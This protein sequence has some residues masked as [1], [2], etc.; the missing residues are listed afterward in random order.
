MPSLLSGSTLRRG[1]SNTFID[2]KGAQPQFP[3]NADTST[4]YTIVTNALFVTTVTSSLGNIEFYKGKMYSNIANQNIQLI[5]TGTSTVIVLGGTA[6]TSTNTGALLVQGGIGI[7]NGLWTGEDIHVNGLTIGQGFK[8]VNNIVIQGA[9]NTLSN[10]IKDGEHSIAIGYDALLG[11]SKSL[12]TI[13]IGRYALSSGTNIAN[14]IAIGDRA[15]ALV[16]TTQT[17]FIS[18]V[19]NISSANPLIVTANNHGLSSGTNIIFNGIVGT[20]ELNYWTNDLTSYY[21]KRL[22]SSTFSLY[23][24]VNLTISV[25][26]TLLTPYVS[27]GIIERPYFLDDNIALGVDAGASLIDGKQNFFLGKSIASNFSTGS[28]NLFIGH[29]V[30]NNMI[31]GNAN[32]AI[33]GDNLIDGVDNQIN[34]G[35]V[36]YYD[37]GGNLQLNANTY[38]GLG[39]ESTS[40]TNGGLVVFGG[41]GISDNLYVGTTATILGNA[42]IGNQLEVTNT[43]TF[44]KDVI[45][46]RD[47]I[48]D[49]LGRVVLSP[50]GNN[51]EIQPSAG[52][53]L[54][55]SVS[56][57]STMDGVKIGTV[58]TPD[59]ANFSDVNIT[60]LW[61]T[62]TIT[63][64]IFTSTNIGGGFKGSLP[65]QSSTGTTAFIP[66]GNIGQV[67][68][69]G[70][71]N[72]ATWSDPANLQSSTASNADNIFIHDVTSNVNPVT[73]DTVFHIA[74]T[75][76]T[77]A[78]SQISGSDNFSYD[79]RENRLT[80]PNLTVTNTLTVIKSVFSQDGGVNENNLLYTPRVTISTSTPTTPRVGDFWI[81]PNFGVELQYID[82][83]GTRFWIQFT[84]I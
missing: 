4:G 25:N 48:A 52:G 31:R 13:A 39:G 83:G 23:Q 73:Q 65:I 71:N 2:L 22:T 6:N 38:L 10:D 63:G 76:A 75:T 54:T 36:F 56:G 21:V 45:V 30:A 15:L 42:F 84:G 69:V 18:T 78:F 68:I 17:E 61:V 81:N 29:D 43:G 41:V 12:K 9:V 33:G 27:G 77:N 34:I 19:S 67:L 5:G 11:I 60:S 57:N 7:Q 28:Y 3:P 53:I 59:E 50:Q 8:G 44:N 70:A 80:V 35:S 1:G 51:V 49:Q 74:L 46:K 58:G 66:I 79:T 64:K 16:G 72:T 24:D 14:S 47:L 37:G 20:T 26:G 62:N 55:I 82:D 40:T 32:I